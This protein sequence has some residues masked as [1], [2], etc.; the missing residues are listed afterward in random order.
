MNLICSSQVYCHRSEIHR[1][2]FHTC[3]CTAV[4][5]LVCTVIEHGTYSLGDCMNGDFTIMLCPFRVKFQSHLQCVL[6]YCVVRLPASSLVLFD[7][8]GP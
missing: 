3:D 4:L 1:N 6:A 8:E 7:C 5:P 2:D